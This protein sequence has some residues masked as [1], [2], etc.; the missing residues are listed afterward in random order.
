MKASLSNII[1]VCEG[2]SNHV[3]LAIYFMKIA[4]VYEKMRKFDEALNQLKRSKHC[5]EINKEDNSPVCAHLLIK[6]AKITLQMDGK[7]NES[8]NYVFSA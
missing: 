8:L 6:I 4:F 5:L 3:K 2:N 7:V 1:S